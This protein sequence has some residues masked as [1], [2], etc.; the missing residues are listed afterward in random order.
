MC[1]PGLVDGI[2]NILSRDW[3]SRVWCLQE[4]LLAPKLVLYCGN[5]HIPW[6]NF[7]YSLLYLGDQRTP[8]GIVPSKLTPWLQLIS[9]RAQIHSKKA[10]NPTGNAQ[11]YFL[12]PFLRIPPET[13][14]YAHHAAFSLLGYAEGCVVILCLGLTTD[15]VYGHLNDNEGPD[16]FL[17]LIPFILL[18]LFVLTFLRLWS[19]TTVEVS[20]GDAIVREMI[21]RRATE[22]Q[23]KVYGV[24]G[25]L[26]TQFSLALSITGSSQAKLSILYRSLFT[27][28]YSKC[29]G[30]GRLLFYA[31]GL[32]NIGEDEWD[33][34][35]WI[36]NLKG[37][38]GSWA[39]PHDRIEAV[40]LDTTARW[41]KSWI[42]PPPPESDLTEPQLL[43]SPV[44]LSLTVHIFRLGCAS[45]EYDPCFIELPVP[46]LG[47]QVGDALLNS[48][49]RNI[50]LLCEP[51]QAVKR[52]SLTMRMLA[53]GV[54]A[55]K[56]EWWDFAIQPNMDENIDRREVR[57][58][59]GILDTWQSRSSGPQILRRL[60]EEDLLRLH[61]KICNNLAVSKRY[62][63]EIAL[64]NG[65]I[66]LANGPS[67]IRTGDEIVAIT[68]Y[69]D[70]PRLAVRRN[71]LKGYHEVVGT[72]F[73]TRWTRNFIS[74]RSLKHAKL[75]EMV[76]G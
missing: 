63:F 38:E 46:V 19:G 30:A 21:L 51:W 14:L 32:P 5:K 2:T 64:D 7:S 36:P 49:L 48:H 15:V 27:E 43:F 61:V 44:G 54:P 67:G 72:V 20:P 71:L 76:L 28:L 47:E 26:Q 29:E 58:W 17:P 57:Q 22:P 55:L 53:K 12:L 66:V 8:A 18:L 45:L 59:A 31:R 75:S 37:S 69:I 74:Q 24:L 39:H 42:R 62:V 70:D 11:K 50:Q 65:G 25:I 52:N 23:D 6:S 68:R 10:S 4:A 9:I 56:S 1:A 73:L 16:W 40:R 13:S 35:S 60:A 34:P 41:S 33:A 3:I